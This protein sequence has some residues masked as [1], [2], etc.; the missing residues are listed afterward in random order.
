[1]K[2]WTRLSVILLQFFAQIYAIQ[3]GFLVYD[4]EDVLNEK[5]VAFGT[6]PESADEH[7]LVEIMD[8]LNRFY[9]RNRREKFENKEIETVKFTVT[10]FKQ[11]DL[12][13]GRYQV[14]I[15]GELSQFLL[16]F[17]SIMKYLIDPS[18]IWANV[19]FYSD[20]IVVM[21]RRAYLYAPAELKLTL[22]RAAFDIVDIVPSSDL[23]EYDIDNEHRR[24]MS[25][26][27]REKR[28][29]VDYWGD[30]KAEVEEEEDEEE[31]EDR[32]TIIR[33]HPYAGTSL[34]NPLIDASPSVRKK[35]RKRLNCGSCTCTLL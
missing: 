31:K 16:S 34:E 14:A 27:A 17:A 24:T 33:F 21:K 18:E 9:R 3:F 28:L 19:K 5:F 35:T 30:F 15:K 22:L 2:N 12:P 8:R 29:K 32:Y 13:D 1:M 20:P 10:L 4:E 23:I 11:E 25:Q 7:H 26:A 6:I